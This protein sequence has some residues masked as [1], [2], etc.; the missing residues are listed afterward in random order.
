MMP[1][2]ISLVCFLLCGLLLTSCSKDL[3]I[4]G[5]PFHPDR[6]D[7]ISPSHSRK[8]D[9]KAALGSP[10]H[11]PAFHPDRWYYIYREVETIA[12]LQPE[13]T[14]QTILAFDFYA[15]DRLKDVY[16]YTVEDNLPVETIE[17]I[18]PSQGRGLT[19]LEQLLASG[20]RLP[21]AISGGAQ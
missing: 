13:T 7:D 2:R 16:L 1:R 21:G 19:F 14:K 9:V 20:A 3:R 11:I 17:R 8:D 15:N 4:S 6:L 10:S 12:F 5:F 18:T